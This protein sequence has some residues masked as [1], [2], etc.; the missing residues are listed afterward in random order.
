[1][2]VLLTGCSS[3]QS[4]L[5]LNARLPTFSRL[6]NN[7]L[8][9]AGHEVVWGTPS[10]SM[11]EEYLSGFDAVVVGLTPPTSVSAYR[12]YGALSVIERA[13]KV[14]KVRYLVDAPEPHRLWSGIRA[15]ANNPSDLIKDFYSKRPEY[16][17][18]SEPEEFERLYSV[19]VDLYEGTWEKTIAPAFPWS[20][21]SN[22]TDYIPN[23]KERSVSLL[24]L[25][26]V[27]LTAMPESIASY[28]KTDSDFWVSNQKTRWVEKIDK[29]INNRVDP[30]IET[31]WTNNSEVLLKMSNAIGSFISTYKNDD[32]WWS[33]NLSQSLYVNT[34][35]VSDWR[36][37]SYLGDSWAAL[38]HQI[39]DMTYQ[40]RSTLA[41]TQKDDYIKSIP[42]FEES[43]ES[44]LTSVFSE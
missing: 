12:L 32:P 4:S 1:V 24:C 28:L 38:A 14:T 23:L 6:I 7:S 33:V 44:V 39:E 19:I 43:V 30:M 26:S 35:V 3:S 18:V 8:E 15:I 21:E 16:E 29:T 36:H 17:K 40:E 42:N 20:N 13:K 22:L 41:D 34:P 2:K 37:T 27:L 10:L 11:T 25:D 31:K 5:S 9:Y